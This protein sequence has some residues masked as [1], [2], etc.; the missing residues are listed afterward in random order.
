MEE[1]NIPRLVI[2]ATG[3]GTGKTTITC[4][5]LQVLVQ[6]N[7]NPMSYKCGPDYIDPMFHS[8]IIGVNSRNLDLFFTEKD[9]VN[10]LL[11]K[12]MEGHSLAIIEGV[13]GYYDGLAGTSY[14][15]STYDLARQTKTPA[16]L[17]V[18]GRGKSLSLVAEIKGFLTLCTDSQIKGVLLN[19][20]S[21]MMYPQLKKLIEEA[22][23]VKVYGYI[24]IMSD[25]QL[26]S[27]HLGLVT[28]KEIDNLQEIV[29]KMADQL[30]ET[31][32]IDGLIT[33]AK[34]ASPISCKP[35]ETLEKSKIPVRIGVALDN[36]FCFYYQDNLDMLTELGAEIIEFSPLKDKKLPEDIQG[37]IFGGGYPELYLKQLS[38]NQS[39][40][41]DI[42]VAINQGMPCLAECGGFM[43][44]HEGIKDREDNLYP[45]V[46]A[47]E[48]TSFPTETLGR[49]GYI[50]LEA[51]E[52]NILCKKGDSIKGHEFHYWD[53]TH[54]GGSF[55]ACKPLRK[56]EWDCIVSRPNLVGGYPHMYFYSNPKVGKNFIRA[57]TGFKTML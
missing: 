13:M 27:R 33:L 51:K 10:C 3:S 48:G 30:E 25:C 21:S 11:A 20:V 2:G 57:C 38:E 18:D 16:I 12:H 40:K 29:T 19:R 23:P 22:L 26:E 6:R 42:K 5:L 14:K 28:A 46:G 34:T 44:L 49:F 36:A 39:M 43:Y 8:E 32:D 31:V 4:G 45:M 50:T 1:M 52:D 54:T 56:K 37:M 55:R 47:L 24:P 35:I 15:A 9:R 7:L 53:S 17:T 41:N